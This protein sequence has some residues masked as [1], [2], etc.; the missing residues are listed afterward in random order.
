MML[1]EGIRVLVVDNSTVICS[2]IAEVKAAIWEG[3]PREIRS[4]TG[5]D[6]RRF[7]PRPPIPPI[8]AVQQ[9]PPNSTGHQ[10][11][12]PDSLREQSTAAGGRAK[13]N[14]HREPSKR[15]PQQQA[16]ATG[17]FLR[18]V[19]NVRAYTLVADEPANRLS[20]SRP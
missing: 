12:Q 13:P 1:P 11:W 20:S 17:C 15:N 5:V 4:A 9:M 18:L 19:Q 7:G 10:A 3:L 8:A 16:Q 6:A 2:M 14:S